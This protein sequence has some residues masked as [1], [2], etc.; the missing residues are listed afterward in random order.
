MKKSTNIRQLLSARSNLTGMRIY[1]IP[2]LPWP[3][4]KWWEDFWGGY[5]QKTIAHYDEAH[6]CCLSE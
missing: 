6:C 4:A 5:L 3:P 2:S 1:L